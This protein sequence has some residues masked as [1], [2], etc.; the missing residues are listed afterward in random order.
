MPARELE[1]PRRNVAGREH[2]G[3]AAGWRESQRPRALPSSVSR[4]R[5]RRR[6]R[7]AP[8]RAGLGTDA[9]R[10]R[11]ARA[12]R[13]RARDE[14]AL[15]PRPSPWVR[16]TP[17]R[18]TP[19]LCTIRHALR[20]GPRHGAH[21]VSFRWMDAKDN[22]LVE[23]AFAT[24]IVSGLGFWQL[25]RAPGHRDR[26]KRRIAITEYGPSR[27]HKTAHRDHRIRAIAI[28]LCVS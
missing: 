2:H 20:W 17:T 14:V 7:H 10:A 25:L 6:W 19:R 24:A 1:E 18:R 27:S 8:F 16:A 13:L 11:V 4:R 22:G 12:T 26:T 5:L 23:V 3:R 21:R 15:A 28:A 9:R